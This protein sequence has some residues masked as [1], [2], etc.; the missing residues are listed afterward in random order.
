MEKAITELGVGEA[1]VS[2]LDADGKPGVVERA[3]ILPPSGQIGPITAE[4]RQ[5]IIRSSALAGVYDEAVDRESAY[6]KLKGKAEKAAEQAEKKESAA[7][8]AG[9][10]SPAKPR[11]RRSDTVVEAVV[12]SAA[13]SMASTAGRQIVRGLLGSIFG[14]RR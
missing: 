7:R 3:M 10:E 11:G 9:K 13:R 6:E 4:E 1:L 14:G 2:F 12:K 8:T 5:A